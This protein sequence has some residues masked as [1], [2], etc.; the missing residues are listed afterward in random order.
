MDVTLY[1]NFSVENKLVKNITQVA[2][3]TGVQVVEATDD[4]DVQIR[5]TAPTDTLKWS[6]V[7]YFEF[8]G[9]YYFLES[10]E[11]TANSISTIN[12]RMDLLMTYQS[13]IQA[14]SVLPERSTSH[15]SMR[16]EDQNRRITVD[17]VRTVVAF[18]NT[19]SGSEG[20]GTYIVTTA[21]SGY[22]TT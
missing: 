21:Q 10:V 20:M 4:F 13:A 3:Y 19:I 1:K 5:M 7:N 12:G 8:D 22:T 17:S 16:L 11:K 18:P 2:K 14:L 15:G 9:A 6:N